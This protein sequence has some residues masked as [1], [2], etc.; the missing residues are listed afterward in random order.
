MK[1]G[2]WST[3]RIVSMKRICRS[4][5]Q[6]KGCIANKSFGTNFDFKLVTFALQKLSKHLSEIII[7]HDPAEGQLNETWYATLK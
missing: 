7:G 5:N 1:A 2:K 3:G 6:V 4:D